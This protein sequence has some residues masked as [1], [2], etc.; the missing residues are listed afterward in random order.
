MVAAYYGH[1]GCVRMLI[2]KEAR[3]QDEK[4]MTALMHA[5]SQGHSDTVAILLEKEKGMLDS[6]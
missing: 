2:E 3:M 4:G 1:A 5:A 6:K